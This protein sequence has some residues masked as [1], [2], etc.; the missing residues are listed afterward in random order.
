MKK[1]GDDFLCLKFRRIRPYLCTVFLK[2]VKIWPL[3]H[4]KDYLKCPPYE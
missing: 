1:S 3:I 2:N 4:R